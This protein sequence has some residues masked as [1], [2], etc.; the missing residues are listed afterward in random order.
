M[1]GQ[2]F[3]CVHLS[4]IPWTV[5]CLVPLFM[6]L[7]S[8]E[9]W[10]GAG[11]GRQIL[12]HWATWEVQTQMTPSY[13]SK[14]CL[15]VWLLSNRISRQPLG[16]LLSIPSEQCSTESW[17]QEIDC[18]WS[19]GIR[20]GGQR[21]WSSFWCGFDGGCAVVSPHVEWGGVWCWWM[22]PRWLCTQLC[23]LVNGQRPR[24]HVVLSQSHGEHK[25]HPINRAF[26]VPCYHLQASGQTPWPPFFFFFPD[27]FSREYN[28]LLMSYHGLWG[29]GA[30]CHFLFISTLRNIWISNLFSQQMLPTCS[31]E[32]K[33]LW[34][35]QVALGPWEVI[36]TYIKTLVEG[37]SETLCLCNSE[38]NMNHN[39]PLLL[40]VHWILYSPYSGPEE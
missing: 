4:S 39:C 11:T 27:S 16:N 20:L 5:A 13:W 35:P 22:M 40:K 10:S 18:L 7:S 36:H 34:S 21:G 19:Y 24:S 26:H 32:E 28:H 25:P 12:Y 1:H 38:N 30:C 3:S 31:E 14:F 37:G 33:S 15:P 2:S 6:G 23:I 8:Q 17:R 29:N 9:Y